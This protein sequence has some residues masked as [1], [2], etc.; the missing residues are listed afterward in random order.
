M[1]RRML[2]TIA[3]LFILLCTPFATAGDFAAKQH[4]ALLVEI[5]KRE[6]YSSQHPA[7]PTISAMYASLCEQANA[8]CVPLVII[9]RYPGKVRSSYSR[10]VMDAS[11]LSLPLNELYA[12]LAH[13]LSHIKHQDLQTYE[14][15]LALKAL[16]PE[17]DLNILKALQAL[18]VEREIAAD[19]FAIS[20]LAK[21]EF[22][23]DSLEKAVTRMQPSST[24]VKNHPN[25]VDRLQ[26]IKQAIQDL[27]HETPL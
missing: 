4:K 17:Q 13:E 16:E 5:A 26:A 14:K 19:R 6:A 22:P 27:E 12:I 21:S 18:S 15:W 7:P 11:L 23:L 9:N 20:L 2:N 24:S 10:I 3:L 8:P 25:L 1:K